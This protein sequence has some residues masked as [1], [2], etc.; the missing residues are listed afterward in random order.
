MPLLLEIYII[1]KYERFLLEITGL[2]IDKEPHCTR[3]C[4]HSDFNMN[5]QEEIE[6]IT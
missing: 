5:N 6:I 2:E 4:M 1:K 3:L